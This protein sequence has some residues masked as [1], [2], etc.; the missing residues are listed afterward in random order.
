MPEQFGGEAGA[1][2]VDPVS[3]HPLPKKG[4]LKLSKNYRIGSLVSQSS[5]AMQRIIINQ[6]KNII[7][8]LK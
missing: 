2:G 6:L 8:S 4:K 7:N 3:D 1:Q 5:K